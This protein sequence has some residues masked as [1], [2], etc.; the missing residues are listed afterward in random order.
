MDTRALAAK[1]AGLKYLADLVK[2]ETDATKT[3]LADAMDEG[4]R[5]TATWTDGQSWVDIGTVSRSRASETTDVV[6]TDEDA[7]IDWVRTHG[8]DGIRTIEALAD[9]KT[10]E[11]LSSARATGEL[12]PGMD[13]V[14]SRRPS[15]VSVRLSPKQAE[16]IA[17]LLR[18]GQLGIRELTTG[19]E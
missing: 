15:Y 2:A 19:D 12:L 14:T 10:A 4:D 3:A 11:L 8:G 7:L 17:A 16:G 9:W 18:S 13:I 6:I 5:K 1:L